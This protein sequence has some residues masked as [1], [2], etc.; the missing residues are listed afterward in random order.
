MCSFCGNVGER[1][2][3]LSIH[4]WYSEG[5]WRRWYSDGVL[6]DQ[7][8]FSKYRRENR[9]LWLLKTYDLKTRTW[10]AAWYNV[11]CVCIEAR[12]VAKRKMRAQHNSTY[13]TVLR[14]RKTECD[15]LNLEIHKVPEEKW[16]YWQKIEKLRAFL[17]L[18]E[19]KL[20][21]SHQD[22]LSTDKSIRGLE[23]RHRSAALQNLWNT[24]GSSYPL[25]AWKA[26]LE[27]ILSVIG[28]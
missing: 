11:G 24:P 26:I 7:Q 22:I 1:C 13:K 21:L 12:V 8:E 15:S 4:V 27:P 6:R 20:V 3:A 16:M 25:W 5:V 10:E 14:L 18:T 28:Q 19:K 2:P 17:S 9:A 23:T